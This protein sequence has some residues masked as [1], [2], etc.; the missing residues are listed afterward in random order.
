MI[1]IGGQTFPS[2]AEMRDHVF[3]ILNN[4]PVDEPLAGTDA[5]MLHELF[6]C[7]PEAEEKMEG[8]QLKHLMVGKHPQAG[9]RAFCI[10]R[11]DDSEDTFSIKK[12]VSAW[13][14]AKGLENVGAKKPRTAKKSTP[15]QTET[16]D[17]GGILNK[18]QRVITLHAE[19]GEEIAQLQKSLADASKQ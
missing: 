15:Q 12:C 3:N 9:A 7:H 8:K 17:A 1:E 10:V 13:I 19:L 18:L 16:P 11:D 6:L 14:R 5:E 2:I 4:S